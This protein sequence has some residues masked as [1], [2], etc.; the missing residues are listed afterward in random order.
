M[1][2][3]GSL[4]LKDE[5]TARSLNGAQRTPT[6]IAQYPRRMKFLSGITFPS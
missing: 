2:L 5:T 4:A 3:I 6:D 1:F